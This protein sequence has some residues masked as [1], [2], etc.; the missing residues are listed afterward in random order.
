MPITLFYAGLLGILYLYLA[1]RVGRYR[2]VSKITFG[3]GDDAEMVLRMRVQANFV[4]YVPLALLI[5]GLLESLS[6]SRFGLHAMGISLAV[7]RLLHA[8]GLS[9]G[10]VPN[11]PRSIGAGLTMLVLLAGCLWGIWRALPGL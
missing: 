5:M 11:L 1:G 9:R 2:G 8:W 3:T 6:V 10:P 7:G 4:E